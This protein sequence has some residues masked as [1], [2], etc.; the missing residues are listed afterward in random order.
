MIEQQGDPL[1]QYPQSERFGDTTVILYHGKPDTSKA[2]AYARSGVVVLL[3]HRASGSDS[4]ARLLRQVLPSEL[5]TS[6]RG[7]VRG[8]NNVEGD[9]QIKVL[10]YLS[11]YT[12]NPPDEVLSLLGEDAKVTLLALRIAL[13]IAQQHL[14]ETICGER[15]VDDKGKADAE[16]PNDVRSLLAPAIEL[17]KQSK[18]VATITDLL[19]EASEAKS[20]G[21]ATESIQTA[22][23]KLRDL[24]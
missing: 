24:H 18:G 14:Q 15:S 4:E 3:A 19:T 6:I 20:A 11:G 9:L 5:G 10:Q 21:E 17:A 1:L 13:E 16:K 12:T 7:L 2:E 22:L 8:W 23:I